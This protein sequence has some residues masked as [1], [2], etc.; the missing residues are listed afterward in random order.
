MET[1]ML[2]RTFLKTSAIALGG[3]AMGEW[4]LA[5]AAAAGGKSQVFFTSDINI[6]GLL[7]IYSKIN[8]GMTG[9]IAIKLHSG[10]PHGPNLLPI[11]LIKGLQPHIPNSTIVECNVLYPSPRQRTETH[12]ETIKTNGFDFCP[13]DIMDADGDADLP[14]RGMRE[15]LDGFSPFDGKQPPYTPGVHLTEI[16]VGKNLLNYDSLFVYTHFKGH[17]MGGFGG[18][19]KNIAIGCASGQ[20]GK[21]QIH[22]DGWPRG[23]LFLE[24][25]VESGKGIADHFGG[26]ITY[27]NVLKNISVDCDCDAHGAK[28]TCNDIG[29]VGS[30]DLLAIDKAS[31]DLLF[32]QPEAQKHDMVE[33]IQSRGGLHQLEYMKTLSM[34]NDD[35]EL[36][37]L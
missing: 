9:K 16:A 5:N 10:E 28:P 19:L 7:K 21:R 29:I 36:I 26:H 6:N 23:P 30:Q 2:R 32:S 34:G 33:R 14:I 20:G 31:V 4:K 15:F 24:R 37:T 27:L 18:S 8:E 11:E 22:G 1:R 35:Y 12:H 25:M 13:V 17:T 3:V